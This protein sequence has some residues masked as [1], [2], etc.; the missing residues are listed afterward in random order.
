MLE[1]RLRE[2]DNVLV[3]FENRNV[4]FISGFESEINSL[5]AKKYKGDHQNGS[6]LFPIA[7][8]NSI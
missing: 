1:I 8:R 3:I 4:N 2:G 5:K 6:C 7:G